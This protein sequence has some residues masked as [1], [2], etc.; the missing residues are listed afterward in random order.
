M[1]RLVLEGTTLS[2]RFKAA[3]ST[4]P[5]HGERQG[6]KKSGKR[7]TQSGGDGEEEDPVLPNDNAT[8]R[9]SLTRDRRSCDRQDGMS[10]FGGDVRAAI[11]YVTASLDKRMNEDEEQNIKTV[12]D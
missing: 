4:S 11:H 6:D 9:L 12:A 7:R 2:V 1:G 10:P 3:R 5:T 8:V